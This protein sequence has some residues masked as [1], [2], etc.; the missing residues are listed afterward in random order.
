[1]KTS[2]EVWGFFFTYEVPYLNTM[3]YEATCLKAGVHLDFL[4]PGKI[5]GV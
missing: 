4:L 1:M 3:P 5:G 2:K